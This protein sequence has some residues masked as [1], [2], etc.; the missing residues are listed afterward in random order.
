MELP[1][2]RQ[3]TG[4]RKYIFEYVIVCL[5]VAV[6]YLFSLYTNLNRFIF[7]TLSKQQEQMIIVIEKNTAVI[8]NLKEK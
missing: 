7:D 2:E 3:L 1:S 8:Q 5:S 6:I 4:I